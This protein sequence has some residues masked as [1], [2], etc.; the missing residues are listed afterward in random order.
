MV[1]IMADIWVTT[2]DKAEI[3]VATV[4]DSWMLWEAVLL[5]ADWIDFASWGVRATVL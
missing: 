1:E 5:M 2:V 4:C 3:S